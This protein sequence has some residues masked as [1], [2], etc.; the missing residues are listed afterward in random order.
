MSSDD[1]NPDE[2]TPFPYLEVVVAK[3]NGSFHWFQC[4]GDLWVLDWVAWWQAAIDRGSQLQELDTNDRFGIHVVN[5]ANADLFL[6]QMRVFEVN[7]GALTKELVQRFPS[8]QSWWDVRDLFPICFVDFDEKHVCACSF[9]GIPFEKYVPLGWTS[10]FEDFAIKYP[11]ERFP[12][13]EKFWVHNGIDMLHEL[14]E[15][16]RRLNSQ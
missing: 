11:E 14:N 13:R 15:R 16:G 1:D 12:I 2:T 5:D 3:H 4:T 10:E 6:Q 9:E 8:A 7:K